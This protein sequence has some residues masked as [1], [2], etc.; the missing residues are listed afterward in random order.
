MYEA[1]ETYGNE[2]SSLPRRRHVIEW[3]LAVLWK[4]P[5]TGSPA[6][7]EMWLDDAGCKKYVQKFYQQLC[8]AESE[9]QQA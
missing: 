1:R 3:T 7:V 6:E 4:D 9:Q 5:P 8:N 2:G